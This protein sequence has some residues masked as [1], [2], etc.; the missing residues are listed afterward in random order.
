MTNRMDHA[1]G[2]WFGRPALQATGWG[3]PC[4]GETCVANDVEIGPAG[5]FLLVTGSNMSAEHAVS[6]RLASFHLAQA[7]GPVCAEQLSMAAGFLAPACASA[8][9][10][11]PGFR[12]TWPNYADEGIVDLARNATSTRTAR[13]C[14]S[15]MKSC[16]A[17]TRRNGTIAVV[18]GA[19]NLLHRGTIGPFPP[20]SRPW[21]AATTWASACRC[22]HFVETLHDER[23]RTAD[24]VRLQ[25]RPASPPPATP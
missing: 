12:S 18:A 11:K 9:R 14:T 5:S 7:G 22:V 13:F 8:T 3:I 19:A 21:P 10:W 2:R 16:W 20:R 6:A 4:C 17:Q 24:D 15:S 25:A 23:A 1:G